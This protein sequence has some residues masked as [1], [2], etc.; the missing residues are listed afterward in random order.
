VLLIRNLKI[1]RI[2]LSGTLTLLFMICQFC[3][4]SHNNVD[5]VVDDSNAHTFHT[6]YTDDIDLLTFNSKFFARSDFFGFI[7][8]IV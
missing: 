7:V 8:L 1:V 4:F 2:L 6:Q 5:L 3:K